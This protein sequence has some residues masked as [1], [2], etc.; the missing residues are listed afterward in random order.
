MIKNNLAAIMPA[1]VIYD[2]VDEKPAG[3][4]QFWLQNVLRQRFNFQGVIFSD[5]LTMEAAGIAGSYSERADQALAAGCDMV[6]VC[7]HPEGAAEILNHLKEYSN[8]V[9][10]LRLMRMHGK[11]SIP[12]DELLNSFRWKKAA[13]MVKLLDENP[14][15]EMDI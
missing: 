2:Q 13:E 9:S 10:Q 11:E 5:D 15:Y 7:N 6:L 4:S 1:H 3:Y 12:R 8:P 14:W